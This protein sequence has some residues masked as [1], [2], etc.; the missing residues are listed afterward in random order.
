L[1]Q[2]F[3]A[4]MPCARM[5]LR[6]ALPFSPRS[7]LSLGVCLAAVR[8]FFVALA[9]FSCNTFVGHSG[10][11]DSDPSP[12]RLR[13]WHQTRRLSSREAVPL[14]LARG[15]EELFTQEL[16]VAEDDLKHIALKAAGDEGDY[17]IVLLEDGDDMNG[18]TDLIHGSIDSFVDPRLKEP[19]DFGAGAWNQWLYWSERQL[20]LGALRNRLKEALRDPTLRVPEGSMVEKWSLPV[21]LVPRA[22]ETFDLSSPLAYAELVMVQPRGQ[23]ERNSRGNSPLAV[24][25]QTSTGREEP[26]LLNFVINEKFKE[27]GIDAAMLRFVEAV[28]RDC[29]GGGR[30]FLRSDQ[31]GLGMMRQ[32]G[33]EVRWREKVD[34]GLRIYMY[35][36]LRPDVKLLT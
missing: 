21:A 2:A 6:S 16:E 5:H 3:S 25:G 32:A 20:T 31:A 1:A 4:Q 36:L 9:G 8:F 34:S 29:W 15:A 27:R 30:L 23:R 19:S 26:Y 28:A 24:Y 12:S 18:L 35:K 7:I 33:Y 10:P 14:R 17:G 22:D 13:G 11:R